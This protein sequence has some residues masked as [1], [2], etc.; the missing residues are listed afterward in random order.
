MY[1]PYGRPD[2][3]G[4]V[5]TEWEAIE[6]LLSYATMDIHYRVDTTRHIYVILPCHTVPLTISG[7]RTA[8]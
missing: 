6:L 2:L 1:M 8:T 5:L 7:A 3:Q 4:N